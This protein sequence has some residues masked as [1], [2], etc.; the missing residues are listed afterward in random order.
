MSEAIYDNRGIRFEYPADWELEEAEDGT[1]T[2]VSIQA[3]SGLAFAIVTIDERDVDPAS[4]VAEALAA[5]KEEYPTLTAESARE[6]IGGYQATG[7]DVE[8]IS[9]ELSVDS[10]L[11]GFQTSKRTLFLM[12][13]WSDLE[14]LDGRRHA[15]EAPGVARGDRR[16]NRRDHPGGIARSRKSATASARGSPPMAK[17]LACPASRTA[18][19]SAGG[20]AAWSHPIKSAK[21]RARVIGTRVSRVPWTMRV[22]ALIRG[23]RSRGRG[24]SSETPAS[25]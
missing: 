20:F 1:R 16:L 5:F 11:R 23:A 8:F 2:V 13:Q 15:P 6:I 4:L 17:T 9:L 10:V 19:N 12:T 18:W 24:R 7:V 21:P 22:G 14:S 25:Q 3:P